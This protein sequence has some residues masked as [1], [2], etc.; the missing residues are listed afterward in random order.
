[1]QNVV[2]CSRMKKNLIYIAIVTPIIVGYV[3]SAP[4]VSAAVGYAYRTIQVTQPTEA[5][6]SSSILGRTLSQRVSLAFTFGTVNDSKKRLRYAEENV[7]LAQAIVEKSQEQK[8]QERAASLIASSNDYLEDLAD[9]TDTLAKKA[10]KN[11]EALFLIE[12]IDAH[13]DNKE[14]VIREINDSIEEEPTQQLQQATQQATALTVESQTVLLSAAQTLNITSILKGALIIP[15]SVVDMLKTDRDGDG[16]S[17][18]QEDAAGTDKNEFDT[19]K[20]GLSDVEEI[21][22]GTDPK[23]IDTD[24]DTF[25]DAYEIARGYS[26]TST[27]NQ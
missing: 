4:T 20:D 26:P 24:G 27:N 23:K 15:Q 13:L 22:L 16:L 11:E 6:I 7:Q 9:R 8:D 10:V 12:D 18:T 2:Y 19:D 3:I 17:D 1:M 14:V 21:R 25:W 5:D